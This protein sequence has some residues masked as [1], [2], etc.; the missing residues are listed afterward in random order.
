M[1]ISFCN[2][3]TA[4]S[5]AFPHRKQ[6]AESDHILG[7]DFLSSSVGVVFSL[8][9]VVFFFGIFKVSI[10]VQKKSIS[11]R[12]DFLPPVRAPR[13]RHAPC[14]GNSNPSAQAVLFVHSISQSWRSW[15]AIRQSVSYVNPSSLWICAGMESRK[16]PFCAIDR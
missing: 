8:G 10:S 2:A 14:G 12:K 11:G 7:R 4:L 15:M 5:A 16:A 9:V 3:P 13:R 6:S 1:S